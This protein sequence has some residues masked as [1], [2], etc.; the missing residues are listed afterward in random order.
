MGFS[1][2]AFGIAFRAQETGRQGTQEPALV[3]TAS[4]PLEVG[5]ET[6][7]GRGLSELSF[8]LKIHREIRPPRAV[9]TPG[10]KYGR[11]G[12]GAG[13]VV[14]LNVVVNAEGKTRDIRVVRTSHPELDQKAIEAV[15]QWTFTPATMDGHPIAVG[16]NIEVP[17]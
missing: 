14:V 1:A 3:A 6:D 17:Y 11:T 13:G 12:H 7:I 2:A 15:S 5:S 8:P 16:V 9:H 4:A 10:P